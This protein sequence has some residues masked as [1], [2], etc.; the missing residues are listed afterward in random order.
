M[1]FPLEA[2]VDRIDAVYGL[3]GGCQVGMPAQLENVSGSPYAWITNV[4]ETA[5][6]SPIIGPVRQRLLFRVEVTC[7]DRTLNGLLHAR[8]HIREA[9]LNYIVT[10]DYEPMTFRAGRMEFADPGW[11]LWRDEYITAYEL[12]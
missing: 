3:T 8:G 2:I 7:G 9:L 11:Y 1:T 4:I 6:D 5:G 12:R 10:P